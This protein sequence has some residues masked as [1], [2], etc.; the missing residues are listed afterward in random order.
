MPKIKAKVRKTP[1]TV[2]KVT[3]GQKTLTEAEAKARAARAAPLTPEQKAA[4]AATKAAQKA[5]DDAK[6]AEA[7]VAQDA[8]RAAAKIAVETAK[9]AVLDS[10]APY[11]KEINVRIEKAAKLDGDAD[12]HRLA[13]ALQLEAARV[14]CEEAKISFK[15]WAEE[16]VKDLAYETIRKLVVVGASE[17]PKL[18]LADMRQKQAGYAKKSRGKTKAS[19]EDLKAGGKKAKAAKPFTVAEVAI[20]NVPDTERPSLLDSAASKI[21]LRVVSKT[22]A[23]ELAKFKQATGTI[24]Q[25]KAVFGELSATHRMAFV[26]WACGEIGG[27][28][29]SEFDAAKPAETV[30]DDMPDVPVSLLR[31]SGVKRG[32]KA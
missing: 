4:A 29:V 9:Q 10:L 13:A 2:V 20:A 11:A 28:F 25:A 31:K 24:E 23:T 32:V 5:V 12:D 21:G 26:T 22:D 16:N 19:I 7:K 15:H 18:A 30:G 3:P 14:K 17:D 27:K 6:K 1:D 8:E